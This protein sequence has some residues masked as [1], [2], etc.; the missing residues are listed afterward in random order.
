M[1]HAVVQSETTLNLATD[2]RS[3][4]RLASLRGQP[5]FVLFRRD[6]PKIRL[7]P[8]VPAA[9]Q[10]CA[11][12]CVRSQNRRRKVQVHRL[13]GYGVLASIASP[14][15]RIHGSHPAHLAADRP[16]FPPEAPAPPPQNHRVPPHRPDRS[17]PD[18]PRP[19]RPAS[20]PFAQ[21]AHPLPDS[22]STRR[23]ASRS[24]QPA[25]LPDRGPVY[26]ASAHKISAWIVKPHK[27]QHQK[28]KWQKLRP[29]RDC[30][31]SALLRRDNS[32]T[33]SIRCTSPSSPPMIH[34]FRTRCWSSAGPCA[35]AS[36]GRN[37]PGPC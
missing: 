24:L 19:A 25:A 22:G 5:F 11:Q 23:I 18:F 31:T 2:S 15:P 16:A 3:S 34:R 13:S 6:H 30:R 7:H 37:H 4:G 8:I 29:S 36:R 35:D 12:N 32:P 1:I 27:Q 14:A 26:R 10:L 33:S 9:A 17:P 20:D 21:T 28:T